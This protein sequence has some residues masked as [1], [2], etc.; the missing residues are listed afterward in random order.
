MSYNL[1]FLKKNTKI[2]IAETNKMLAESKT[3]FTFVP[4]TT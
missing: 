2:I 4:K 3:F 1:C